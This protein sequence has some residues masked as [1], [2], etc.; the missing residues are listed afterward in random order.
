MWCAN[1]QRCTD[2]ITSDF[3]ANYLATGDRYNTSTSQPNNLLDGYTYAA[4]ADS[5]SC[6]ANGYAASTH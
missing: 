5:D 4:A 1:A 3:H 2:F 6:T